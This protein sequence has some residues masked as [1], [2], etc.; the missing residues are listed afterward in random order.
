MSVYR[1]LP[2]ARK[3]TLAFG[4]V[5]LLCVVL[6]AYSYFTFRS[7]VTRSVD[8]SQNAFPSVVLLGKIQVAIDST[9]RWDLALL[10]CP[11][12][13]CTVRDT[14]K[15]QEA[16]NDYQTAVR[17]YESFMSDREERKLYQ[18]FTISVNRYL[19]ISERANALRAEGKTGDALDLLIADSTANVFMEAMDAVNADFELNTKA[20][21]EGSREVT[22]TGRRAIWINTGVTFLIVALSALVG[23][24]LT[25]VIA[26]RVGRAMGALQQLAG[27]DLTA[28]LNVS[29][30]DEIGQLGDALNHSVDVLRE[31]VKSVAQGAETLSA[32]TTE[33]SA[34]SVQTAGNANTQC[35][36][37]NQI[38]AAAHELTAT[39]GEIGH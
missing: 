12:A 13:A 29:G 8:V 9:R 30:S 21:S 37:T 18:K 6:G 2:I 14:Q 33:M 19:E 27:K 10:L 38:A 39:I 23:A 35:N 20:G 26:P 25:K 15:R 11:N 28:H 31:L 17:A 22:Q 34:R 36:R 7:I 4:L 5:C 16:L 3:F 24:G 1:N 32:A